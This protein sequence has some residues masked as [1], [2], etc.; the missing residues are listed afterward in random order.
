MR[1]IALPLARV[2]ISQ[3]ARINP[4]TNFNANTLLVYYHFDLI[5]QRGGSEDL[6]WHKKARKRVMNKVADLWAGFGKAP[7][8]SWKVGGFLSMS[9]LGEQ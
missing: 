1:I 6:S 5:S 8:G 3:G 9:R 2:K 4:S 7:K